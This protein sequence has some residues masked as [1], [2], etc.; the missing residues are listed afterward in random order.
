MVT[1]AAEL[2]EGLDV[3]ALAR[4]EEMV[5]VRTSLE[6][7]TTPQEAQA[8]C[9]ELVRFLVTSK[10]QELESE[11]QG[12]LH[13]VLEV[14]EQIQEVYDSALQGNAPGDLA[15][16]LR[17]Q[18]KLRAALLEELVRLD[19][20]HNLRRTEGSLEETLA[21][22][23]AGQSTAD[24]TE[25]GAYGEPQ[26]ARR[27]FPS[28]PRASAARESSVD[29]RLRDAGLPLPDPAGQPRALTF[30]AVKR[31]RSYATETFRL[32]YDEGGIGSR[33]A[34]EI[35]ATKGGVQINFDDVLAVGNGRFR[36]LEAKWSNPELGSVYGEPRGGWSAEGSLRD[37]ISRQVGFMESTQSCDGI[38]FV[39]NTEESK[40][41]I[42]RILES[43]GQEVTETGAIQIK[44]KPL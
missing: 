32:L 13:K 10:V 41:E 11:F 38:T 23:E 17:P 4:N 27:T 21:K 15:D 33:D 30:E 22:E 39:T 43:M 35:M 29:A 2:L 20:P 24:V 3:A 34:Y 25:G 9:E 44:V 1:P 42:T 36:I 12:A 6:Q 7:Q 40:V 31:Q 26:Q 16:Q 19:D 5:P 18:L 37:E 14:E 28:R 8:I